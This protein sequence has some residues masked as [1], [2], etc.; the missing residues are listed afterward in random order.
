LILLISFD[1]NLFEGKSEFVIIRVNEA[2]KKKSELIKESGVV[3][4]LL[5]LVK[6]KDF[7]LVVCY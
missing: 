1:W 4:L 5:E 3:V 6:S 2:A 7:N